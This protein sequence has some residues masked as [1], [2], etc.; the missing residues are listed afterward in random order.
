MWSFIELGQFDIFVLFYYQYQMESLGNWNNKIPHNFLFR[1]SAFITFN[2]IRGDVL[3][4]ETFSYQNSFQ[5]L[6]WHSLI[7]FLY[8]TETFVNSFSSQCRFY[9]CE[10]VLLVKGR[11]VGGSFFSPQIYVV[12][13]LHSLFFI[14]IWLHNNKFVVFLFIFLCPVDLQSKWT[15]KMWQT[16]FTWCGYSIIS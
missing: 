7:V 14:H 11:G 16:H 3:K 9:N 5:S 12:L 6:K 8:P 4:V 13:C 15:V 2:S 1:V 10:L